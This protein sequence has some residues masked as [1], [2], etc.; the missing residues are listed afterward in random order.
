MGS[1]EEYT[2]GSEIEHVRLADGSEVVADLALTT[3]D[4]L[5]NFVKDY[6]FLAAYDLRGLADGV[7]PHITPTG[8]LRPAYARCALGLLQEDGSFEMHAAV[9]DIVRNAIHINPDNIFEFRL[10]DPTVPFEGFR[11]QA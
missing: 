1:P 8:D 11:P 2:E 7:Q 6:Q 5:L 10:T 9:A 3:M 4:H